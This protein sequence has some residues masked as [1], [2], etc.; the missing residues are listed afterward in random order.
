MVYIQKLKQWR[1]MEACGPEMW[2]KE[3]KRAGE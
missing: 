2:M 3:R 1:R